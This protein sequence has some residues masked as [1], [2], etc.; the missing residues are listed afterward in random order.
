MIRPLKGVA[1][2]TD[3]IR[4]KS[5]PLPVNLSHRIQDALTRQATREAKR[6]EIVLDGS[7][8]TLRR[9]CAKLT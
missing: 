1:G 7:V 2:I 9:A 5:L 8:V 4:L 6:I 3:N